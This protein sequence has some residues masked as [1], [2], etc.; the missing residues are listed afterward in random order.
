MSTARRSRSTCTARNDEHGIGDGRPMQKRAAR[1]GTRI[2]ASLLGYRVVT[3]DA[4]MDLLR[5]DP[6]AHSRS[7]FPGIGER[8]AEDFESLVRLDVD[9]HGLVGRRV[10]SHH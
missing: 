7:G 4:E 3:A 1:S 2:T 8:V 5:L 10:V 9:R 6:Q